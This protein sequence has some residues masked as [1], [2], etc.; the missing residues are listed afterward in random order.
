MLPISWSVCCIN[1]HTNTAYTDTKRIIIV[2][3]TLDGCV[4]QPVLNECYVMSLLMLWQHLLKMFFFS[5]EQAFRLMCHSLNGKIYKSAK[6]Q[7]FRRYDSGKK[8]LRKRNSDR[9]REPQQGLPNRR[10]KGLHTISAMY[11]KHIT[12]PAVRRMYTSCCRPV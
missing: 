4:W 6:A 9:Y 8:L 2:Y 7:F 11:S 3:L 10:L 12:A 5:N 1:I